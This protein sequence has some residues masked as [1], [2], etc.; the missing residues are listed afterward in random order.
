MPFLQLQLERVKKSKPY[1]GLKVLQNIPLT[2]E[3][4]VK[5]EILIEGGA[6]VY[7]TSPSFMEVDANLLSAFTESGG[8]FL[9]SNQILDQDFDIHLDC[10]AELLHKKPP[11]IGT[12]EITGTGTN[13]YGEADLSFP[14]ISIDLSPVKYL[15]G[16]LGTGEA[17]VRAFKQL[18]SENIAHKKFMI[19]GYGKVGRGM[20]H[21]LRKEEAEVIVVEKNEQFL[22]QARKAGFQCVHAADTYKIETI[23]KNCF[24]VATATGRENVISQHYNSSVFKNRY[25]AN[26]GGDDEFGPD[27]LPEEVMCRKRPINFFIDKPTLLRYLDP[28]FYAHNMAIDILLLHPFKKGLHP[29]PAFI[30]D[31]IVITWQKIFNEAIDY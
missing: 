30:A 4:I 3:T 5:L 10:A 23:V 25:L 16:V 21:Y 2:F 24:C 11:K 7:T 14:V 18:T 15:E 28:V 8:R 19:F 20:A 26:M 31:E 22:E 12:V 29:F 1:K 9:T 6:D 27:F 13:K 17:F